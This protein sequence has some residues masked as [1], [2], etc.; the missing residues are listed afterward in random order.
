MS[1]DNEGKMQ[2]GLSLQKSIT[3]ILQDFLS[4]KYIQS[5]ETDYYIGKP[6][7]Q[8]ERQ[9]YAAFLV[10]I[11][12]E[13]KWA[14]YSTTSM[15]DR[16]KGQLWDAYN[17]KA[18][19]SS[20]SKAF[21]VY[22]DGLPQDKER[23][24]LRRKNDIINKIGY[25]PN[26]IDDILSQSEFVNLLENHTL[27][28]TSDGSKRGIL[29]NKFED[30]VARLLSYADNLQ[31]WQTN[32]RNIE[33]LHYDVFKKIVNCFE[34]PPNDTLN[35]EASSE[36]KIIGKLP[37]GGNPKTD[38][39]VTVSFKDHTE[40]TYT[41]SCKRSSADKVS[42][43]DYTADKFA[44]VLDPSNTELKDLL[45][46]F[47]NAGGPKRLGEEKCD[48][49]TSVIKPYIE[50]LSKWALGG[51]GGDGNPDTQW[52]DYIMVYNAE[53]NKTSIHRI[54]KYIELLTK[55][56]NNGTFGTPFG[57]T[58]PSKQLGKRIQLKGKI[59]NEEE[60]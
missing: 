2:H 37:S 16:F 12:S 10:E 35:I 8:N 24:F 49:L 43:H 18:I 20:I 15:K 14:I 34:L 50:K 44:S 41:I 27:Q 26:T 4:Q 60:E 25:Y 32:D 58:Y 23:D 39:L 30:R 47:Q 5:F 36:K 38:V 48:R 46:D 42:I 28:D 56:D 1:S 54:E 51:H 53:T 21:L 19:D 22:P 59:I 3:N 13:E 55:S 17:L 45:N 6:G 9:F 40:K 52:A 29:G 33:G 57:W 11:N 7:Y 31:K